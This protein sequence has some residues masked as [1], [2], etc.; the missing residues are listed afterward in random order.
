VRRGLVREVLN[1]LRKTSCGR[2][3]ELDIDNL[4]VEHSREVQVVVVSV[5]VKAVSQRR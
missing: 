2:R 3:P 5:Y 1:C 4:A